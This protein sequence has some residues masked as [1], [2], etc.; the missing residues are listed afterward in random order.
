[1]MMKEENNQFDVPFQVQ[2]LIASMRDKKERVHVRGNY[3]QRLA[4]IKTAIDNALVE[5]DREMGNVIA[6]KFKKGR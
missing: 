3:R 4:A 1:M 6:P 2:T 5:Y